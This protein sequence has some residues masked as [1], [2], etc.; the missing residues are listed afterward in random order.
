MTLATMVIHGRWWYDF[1]TFAI[2]V[3]FF[4]VLMA[5]LF[6]N[7]IIGWSLTLAFFALGFTFGFALSQ[8]PARLQPEDVTQVTVAF[9]VFLDLC[10]GQ[11]IA[12]LLWMRARRMTVFVGKVD[13]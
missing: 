4:F 7:S 10:L 9:R 12:I 1:V 5:L 13:P 3:A 8:E 2:L 11:A 6:R